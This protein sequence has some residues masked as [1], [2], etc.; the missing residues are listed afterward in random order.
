MAGPAART[1]WHVITAYVLPAF[2]LAAL[3]MPIVVHL[4]TFYASKEVG[5]SLAV[6]G[7]IFGLMRMMDVLIDPLAGY[8]SDR[9]RTPFG[10]RRP[11][12][13]LAAPVLA[14]GIWLAFVPG[15]PV[16]VPYLC[17]CL[18]VM[19]LGWSTVL[20]PHLSWGSE[21][22]G[23]YHERSRIY[24]WFQ[25][26][27]V[28]GMMGVLVLPAILEAKGY[29]LSTQVM[30]MAI[31]SI[32]TLVPS[33]V[34]C[35]AIVPEP[36]VKLGTQ[37]GLIPTLKFLLKN[38]AIRRI[39]AVDLLE[40]T[41]QGARGAMFLYFATLGLGLP[42]FGGTLLLVY[43]LS[44]VVF[45]PAWIA[46][47]RRL[48]KHRTLAVSYVYQIVVGAM[49]FLI[50]MGDKGIAVTV[51]A[52]TGVSYAAPAFLIRAM[53]ADITDADTHETGAERAGLM[54]AFLAMTSKLGIGWSVAIAFGVLALLGFDPKIHN[55]P[56]A[57]EHLRYV[58][59]LMPMALA[60]VSLVTMLGYPLGEARQRELRAEIERRRSAEPDTRSETAVLAKGTAP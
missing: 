51:I 50:P 41:N 13:A 22:S 12:I 42:K 59:I 39:M 14:L 25:A 21:L 7:A 45:A 40:S 57:V 52:L 16:S 43:F 8:L 10:R 56:A 5:L 33:I 6:V 55:A 38:K 23:D 26:A 11:V 4:P 29:P 30:A 44:G 60:A 1:P 36:E 32:V 53:M 3:G 58:N 18:F 27:T 35:I 2:P 17:G 48:G 19:Y 49:L 47:S 54:Y 28:A 15:G 37:A 34:L 24:G 31:F 20:V 46:L 9:W